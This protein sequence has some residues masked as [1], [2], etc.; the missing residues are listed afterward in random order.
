MKPIRHVI[1]HWGCADPEL[2][3]IPPAVFPQ[4]LQLIASSSKAELGASLSNIE[5]YA[6]GLHML[7]M[8]DSKCNPELAAQGKISPQ[9]A[10]LLESSLLVA[11]QGL[12]ALSADLDQ[13]IITKAYENPFKGNEFAEM[14]RTGSWFPT[15]PLVRVFPWFWRDNENLAE[16]FNR[17]LL[18]ATNLMND[19]VQQR[20]QDLESYGSTC[21]KHKSS[22]HGLV[23]GIFTVFCGGCG[24]C[25]GFEIMPIAESPATAFQIFAQ[26]AWVTADFSKH[27]W[28]QSHG[29]WADLM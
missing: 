11:Q 19:V 26:R 24:A 16:R 27:Q 20:A 22:N 5:L 10:K 14:I 6:D 25:E 8:Y 21:H 13:V 7:M 28:H 4:V 12:K 18:Q 1:A 29:I 2:K 23:P 15:H 9:L 3:L 17:K